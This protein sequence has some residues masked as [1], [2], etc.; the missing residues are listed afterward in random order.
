M[1]LLDDAPKN[2]R[3]AR[4]DDLYDFFE[5]A[6]RQGIVE[7]GNG[8][9]ADVERKPIDRIVIHHTSNPPG[10][11]PARL[12][13]IELVR[14]YVPYFA[15]PQ[16][17]EDM[18]LK[19]KP[20]SSGHVRQGKQVFWPYHWIVRSNGHAERLLRDSEIGWHAGNWDINCRS[21]AIVFDN[22]YENSRPSSIELEAAAALIR[23]RYGHVPVSGIL[24]HCE[25]N[26]KTV[27]PSRKFLDGRNGTGWKSDLVGR[28]RALRLA[29]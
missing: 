7:L 10:L 15:N 23:G 25:T 20:I 21:V 2:I 26:Q 11:S 19:G 22:D 12:S 17:P 6:L 27:C 14:L 13:A 28:V 4:K 29:A 18:H 24:G 16:A 1:A 8:Y 5:Q 9:D 3:E